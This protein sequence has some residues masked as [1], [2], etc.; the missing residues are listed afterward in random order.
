M[1]PKDIQGLR[2]TVNSELKQVDDEML[3]LIDHTENWD[4]ETLVET[5]IP[6]RIKAMSN[7]ADSLRKIS[8]KLAEIEAIPNSRQEEE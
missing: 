6:E 5:Y 2:N 7:H 4:E 1:T 8:S 3:R